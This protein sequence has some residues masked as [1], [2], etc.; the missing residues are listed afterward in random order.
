MSGNPSLRLA[1]LLA[2]AAVIIGCEPSQDQTQRRASEDAKFSLEYK[3]DRQQVLA[4]LENLLANERGIDAISLATRFRRYEDPAIEDVI[5]RAQ[6]LMKKQHIADLESKVKQTKQT[7][8]RSLVTYYGELQKLVPENASYKQA[9]E[10]HRSALDKQVEVERKR[11]EAA[12]RGRRRTQGV[13]IGM[14]KE[15]VLMSQWGKPERV[16]ART[17]TRGTTEQWVYGNGHYLYFD[18]SGRLTS[19]TTRR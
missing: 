10:R 18:E 1:T 8:H 5:R 4:E 17:S 2:C 7:D 11:A 19:V 3:K 6:P 14:S 13:S 9:W 16:N 15:E 12:D